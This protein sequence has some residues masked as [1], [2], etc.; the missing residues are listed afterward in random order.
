MSLLALDLDSPLLFRLCCTVLEARVL[1]MSRVT[2]VT[3]PRLELLRCSL[4]SLCPKNVAV[5]AV[6]AALGVLTCWGP[7]VTGVT[8]IILML[9]VDFKP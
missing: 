2:G 3:L 1:V 6:R 8:V 9:V 4:T 7:Q 5:T